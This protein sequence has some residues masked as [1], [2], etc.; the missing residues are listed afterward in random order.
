MDRRSKSSG[1]LY[2]LPRN[3]D[4]EPFLCGFAAALLGTAS[5]TCLRLLLLDPMCQECQGR[6]VAFKPASPLALPRESIKLMRSISEHVI[7]NL[8]QSAQ[9]SLLL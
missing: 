5:D 6:T 2:V 1:T 4:S 9:V 7:Q 8:P 3:S